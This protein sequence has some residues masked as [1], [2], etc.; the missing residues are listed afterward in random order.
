M[1]VDAEPTPRTFRPL[2]KWPGGKAREWPRVAPHLPSDVRHF[3]DPFVGGGA[4]FALTPFAGSAF[5]NDRHPR[6]IDLYRRVQAGDAA[7]LAACERLGRDWD[8]LAELA[9][10][11]VVVFADLLAGARA[12]RAPDPPVDAVDEALRNRPLGLLPLFAAR[13]ATLLAASLADKARRL[14]RL[15][16]KHD[17]RFEGA[18]VAPHEETAVRAAYYTL[19]RER[20]RSTAGAAGTADFLFVR[21]YCYGSMFR[22]NS[23]GEFNIPYGGRSYNAKPFLRRVAQLADPDLRASLEIARFTCLDFEEHLRGL[24]GTLDRRDLVFLDPPYDSDFSTYGGHRFDLAEHERLASVV[25]GLEARWLLV[26]KDTEDV[27]RIYVRGAPGAAGARVLKSFGKQY[28]Y[29][30][31]GRNDRATQHLLIANY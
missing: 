19:V 2:L 25:A 28:G 1:S 6:L 31:R 4:P 12:G 18:D 13:F 29:N 9:A 17:V 23:K 20:E 21:D 5:L 27:Q 26:I 7:F 11:L 10:D 3:V 14:A 16:S 15:E 22:T 24:A 30:V 8:A